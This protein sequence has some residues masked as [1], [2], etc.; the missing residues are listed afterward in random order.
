MSKQ[1]KLS[2]VVPSLNHG[3]F[4]GATLDSLFTQRD[5]RP[6]ELEV[7]V[8]DGGSRD[9]TVEIIKRY[10]HKIDQWVS[11]P[12]AGQT[13]ALIKGFA[14]ATGDILGWLCSDDLLEPWT[15]RQVLDCFVRSAD[16]EF[17]YGDATWIDK[18]GYPIKF[19]K[20]IPF[21]WYIWLHDHNY[22]P[23]PA[24]FWRRRLYEQ[25]GGLDRSFDLAMDGDL[26]A[27]LAKRSPPRHVTR[28]W[29]RLRSYPEQKNKRLRCIS[30]Q[31]DRVI[32]ERLGVSYEN[33][34]AV[35]MRY[36]VAKTL[37]VGWKLALGA[38]R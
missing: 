2:V 10:G 33:P 38:F 37:R 9:N 16:A 22:I 29:A 28:Q 3:E 21:N 6:G 7:I 8:M 1:L 32:R 17:L 18:S 24:A 20:E 11:E 25:A 4:I 12:D 23:Q 5:I 26:F 13:D 35:K 15:V 36:C 19:K 27:R 34:I 30:D 14:R 31:E